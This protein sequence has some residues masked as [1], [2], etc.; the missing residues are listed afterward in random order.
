MRIAGD[1][2]ETRTVER[3]RGRS[4]VKK[5]KRLVNLSGGGGGGNAEK[6]CGLFKKRGF[7]SAAIGARNSAT[8]A[9]RRC[10]SFVFVPKERLT[11][12]CSA[13]FF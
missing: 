1:P 8:S 12:K 2:D 7:G 4:A 10:G 3:R 6:T 9:A 5:A 11:G 13:A